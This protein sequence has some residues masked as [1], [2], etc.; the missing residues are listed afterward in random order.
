MGPS[1]RGA[2]EG[3]QAFLAQ[4]PL[5]GLEEACPLPALLGFYEAQWIS[6][7]QLMLI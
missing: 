2:M 7:T 5:S 3:S 4:L 1:S 6:A